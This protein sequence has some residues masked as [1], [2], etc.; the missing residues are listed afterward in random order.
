CKFL[1]DDLAKSNWENGCPIATVTLE[2][3]SQKDAIQAIAKNHWKK[4]EAKIQEFL[5]DNKVKSTGPEL[6][7]LIIT[8]IEGSLLLARAYK[9]KDPLIQTGKILSELLKK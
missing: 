7:N 1:A 8:S 9:S 2:I 5:K 3:A 4:W 6:V